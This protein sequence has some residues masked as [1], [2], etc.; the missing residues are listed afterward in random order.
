MPGHFIVLSQVVCKTKCDVCIRQRVCSATCVYSAESLWRARAANASLF[1][2]AV[3]AGAQFHTVKMKTLNFRNDTYCLYIYIYILQ[4]NI[5]YT[6]YI[7]IY[8]YF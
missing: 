5:V 2:V 6:V 8:M 4:K 7:Y 1:A 3:Q